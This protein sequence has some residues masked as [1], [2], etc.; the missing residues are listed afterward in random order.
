MENFSVSS[1]EKSAPSHFIFPLQRCCTLGVISSK[2][3]RQPMLLSFSFKKVVGGYPEEKGRSVGH[4]RLVQCPSSHGP[5]CAALFEQKQDGNDCSRHLFTW[6]CSVRLLFVPHTKKGLKGKRFATVEEVKQK[7]L[8]GLKAIAL[9][10]Q[11]KKDWT[12]S[13]EKILVIFEAPSYYEENNSKVWAKS[14]IF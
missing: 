9:S 10:K 1:C 12:K 6:S 5:L 7:L 4:R 13:Y 2:W 8:E 14:L 3:N 11:W